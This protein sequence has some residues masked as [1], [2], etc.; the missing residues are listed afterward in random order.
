[1]LVIIENYG[2]TII[3]CIC[4]IFIFGLIFH[5][6]EY[7]GEQGILNITGNQGQALSQ[8]QK[9]TNVEAVEYESY[10]LKEGK[11][12]EVSNHI[13]ANKEYA[14]EDIFIEDKNAKGLVVFGVYDYESGNNK[15]EFIRNKGKS[16]C[17]MEKGIY[18]IDVWHVNGERVDSKFSYF[19]SV[20]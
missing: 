20:N 8:K 13:Q 14:I 11:S 12:L 15:S 19:V 2:K 4:T 9:E 10:L 7:E 1:M 3:I 5:S 16:I 17:F 6:M 18:R